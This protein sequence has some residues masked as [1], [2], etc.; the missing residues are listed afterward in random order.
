[1]DPNYQM[2]HQQ[3]RMR[4]LNCPQFYFCHE[5][6]QHAYQC[7]AVSAMIFQDRVHQCFINLIVLNTSVAIFAKLEDQ[8][9]NPS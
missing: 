7:K 2:I 1:M 6:S 9:T 4:A 3:N 8:L 5:T